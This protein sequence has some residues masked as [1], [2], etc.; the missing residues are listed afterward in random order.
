[1]GKIQPTFHVQGFSWSVIGAKAARDPKHLP[2]PDHH[3]RNHISSTL[4]QNAC[5][6]FSI[7]PVKN[8]ALSKSCIAAPED[9]VDRT[10]HN[11][12]TFFSKVQAVYNNKFKPAH[13]EFRWMKSLK[14]RFWA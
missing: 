9:P 12:N 4:S 3:R 6:G 14:A 2:T 10:E 11:S 8:E 5:E 1:M 13:R 7:T